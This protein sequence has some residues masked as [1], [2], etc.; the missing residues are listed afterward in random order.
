[1]T[2]ETPAGTVPADAA[3]TAAPV[4]PSAGTVPVSAYRQTRRPPLTARAKR[5]T[6]WAGA[7]GFNLLTLGFTFVIVPIAVALLGVFFAAIIDQIS[8]TN[9][10]LS[11]GF[12]AIRGFFLSL[13]FGLF[14][15]I[16]VAVVVVGLAIMAGAL[17]ASRA[18]LRAH[19]V[20]RPSAVTW[21][22]AGIAIVAS[23]FLGWI[24]GL[25]VQLLSAALSRSGLDGF[26]TAI[27]AGSVGLILGIAMTAVMGWLAWWWMAH[28]FRSAESTATGNYRNSQEVQG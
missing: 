21:A 7:V 19:R 27:T 13:D 16:G 1:M 22:G 26:A 8:R 6:F 20:H 11:T 12:L 5:G 23:W 3:P 18:I 4:A 28:A 25:I 14:A 10:Q 15:I 17:L 24:P 2:A 9:D